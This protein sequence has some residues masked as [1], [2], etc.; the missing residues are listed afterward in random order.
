MGHHWL[1]GSKSKKRRSSVARAA[2]GS[3][4]LE[5]DRG[6]PGSFRLRPGSSDGR[7]G[8]SFER[9]TIRQLRK[10]P[11]RTRVRLSFTASTVW[12]GASPPSSD[13]R[14]CPVGS[15][16]L[17]FDEEETLCSTRKVRALNTQV[18][19]LSVASV[20]DS[21]RANVN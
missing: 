15:H 21:A 8:F 5:R 13:L 9:W 11:T 4:S 3:R 2:A 7:L 17:F 14:R 12:A 10:A 16:S 19:C 6:C 18:W 20:H 1:R